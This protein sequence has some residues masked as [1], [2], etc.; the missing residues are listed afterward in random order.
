ME[1]EKEPT[2]GERMVGIDYNVSSDERVA[3]IKRQYA[4][5][6]DSLHDSKTPAMSLERANIISDAIKATVIASMLSVKA[7]TYKF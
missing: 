7:I 4:E 2:Y 3:T 1:P 6:I 5:I